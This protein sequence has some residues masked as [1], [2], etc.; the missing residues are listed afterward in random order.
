MTVIGLL[1][2]IHLQQRELRL[3]R[4][5]LDTSKNLQISV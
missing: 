3:T 4:K 2:T 5:E 1:V